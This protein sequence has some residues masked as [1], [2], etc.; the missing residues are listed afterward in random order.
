MEVT[1]GFVVRI[2]LEAILEATGGSE[3]IKKKTTKA[4]YER[5]NR[6]IKV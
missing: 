3:N 2:M 6:E 5:K 4:E 1:R